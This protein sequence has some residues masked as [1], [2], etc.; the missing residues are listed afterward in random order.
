MDEVE[1]FEAR[2][3]HLHAGLLVADQEGEVVRVGRVACELLGQ[4]PSALLGQRLGDLVRG[5]SGRPRADVERAL[6]GPTW[7]LTWTQPG[8]DGTER[9]LR[10]V[11]RATEEGLEL[12]IDDI[13]ERMRRAHELNALYVLTDRLEAVILREE[14]AA[15][16]A[17]DLGNLLDV[18]ASRLSEGS[19]ANEVRALLDEAIRVTKRLQGLEA[20]GPRSP[21]GPL[22][23]RDALAALLPLLRGLVGERASLELD[24]ADGGA[25]I[26]WSTEHLRSVVSNLVVNAQRAEARSVVLRT[27]LVEGPVEHP[28]RSLPPGRWLKLSVRDDGA[29]MDAEARALALRLAPNGS[30]AGAGL[31]WVRY[32][33]ERAGGAIELR[34]EEGGGMTA[35]V[36]VP[37]T[38]SAE[39]ASTSEGG[40]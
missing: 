8:P 2:T 29:V 37:V 33:V 26:A 3:R 4:P 36:Y 22:V 15:P 6:L 38:E 30:E 10:S 16:L 17:V 5:W 13:S 7:T 24:L 40:D 23:V 39:S 31:P 20:G 19:S 28:E 25:A 14:R 32:L 9:M 34:A 21:R 11:A 1:R 35:S 18:L 27:E 12:V